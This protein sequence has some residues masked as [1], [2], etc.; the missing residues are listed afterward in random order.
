[1]VY[2]Y[3]LWPYD[4]GFSILILILILL[5][6]YKNATKQNPVFFFLH[7]SSL[8]Y[9]HEQKNSAKLPNEQTA[10]ANCCLMSSVFCLLSF[11][12]FSSS[13]Y[14]DDHHDPDPGR[15][16]YPETETETKMLTVPS[17]T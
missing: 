17:V 13:F 7:P 2:G 6:T 9:E 5:C 4:A 3:G 10:L 1:M 16:I 8:E 14:F 11:M 15:R 12:T